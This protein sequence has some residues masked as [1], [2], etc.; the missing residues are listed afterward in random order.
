MGN[1]LVREF[2]G[3]FKKR[4]SRF[5]AVFQLSSGCISLSIVSRGGYKGKSVTKMSRREREVTLRD[6][7]FGHCL[8]VGFLKCLY[9]QKGFYRYGSSTMC[10]K[11][12]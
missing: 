1:T 5:S 2:Q 8:L 12:F 7:K 4:N 10:K 11:V 9:G 3:L 6:L